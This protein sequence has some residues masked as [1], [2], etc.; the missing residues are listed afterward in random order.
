MKDTNPIRAEV[1]NTD[2][3]ITKRMFELLF[4]TSFIFVCMTILYIIG[5]IS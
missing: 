2:D 3:V 5:V 1:E 4:I